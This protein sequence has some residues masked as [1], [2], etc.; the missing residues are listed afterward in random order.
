MRLRRRK[1]VTYRIFRRLRRRKPVTYQFQGPPPF[2]QGPLYRNPDQ[3][4]LSIVKT[5]DLVSWSLKPPPPS[6]KKLFSLQVAPIFWDQQKR[7]FCTVLLRCLAFANKASK[8]NCS[9]KF[10]R[11]FRVTKNVRTFQKKKKSQKN[12]EQAMMLSFPKRHWHHEYERLPR[13]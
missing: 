3:N 4:L 6:R 10:L 7:A 2:G 8:E 5:D 1:L 9:L 11:L 12:W 13:K